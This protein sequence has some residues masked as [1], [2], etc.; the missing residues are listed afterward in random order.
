MGVPLIDKL[1]AVVLKLNVVNRS[2]GWGRFKCKKW[3]QANALS[4]QLRFTSRPALWVA[5]AK[6]SSGGHASSVQC[7]WKLSGHSL[8][9]QGSPALPSWWVDGARLRNSAKLYFVEG[10]QPTNKEWMYS[11]PVDTDQKCVAQ[12]SV[13]CTPYLH[14]R[15]KTRGPDSQAKLEH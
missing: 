1:L 6:Y 3:A 9:I 13:Q 10:L 7:H 4:R 14:L 12:F 15:D 11:W 5:L 2:P 8:T